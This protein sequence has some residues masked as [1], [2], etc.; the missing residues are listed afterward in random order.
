MSAAIY[1]RATSSETFCSITSLC[2]AV[3]LSRSTYYRHRVAQGT[4]AP[5]MALREAI[6]QVA[7]EMPSYGY[8]RITQ[9]LHR[10]GMPVNH[11][12]VLRLMREDNLLCLRKKPFTVT[13]DSAHDLPVYPN[14]A[15]KRVVTGLNQLWVSDITYIRLA[16]EFIYR[17]VILDACSRPV[18]S[19]HISRRLDAALTIAALEKA[20]E[21]RHPEP[22]LVHPSDRGVQYAATKYTDLLRARGIQISMS[23]RGN[24]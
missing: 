9:E 13:T 10:Q 4:S 21:E 22:G 16:S 14:L 7:L 2:R 23:R 12:R 6:Q 8:R 24:P 17:A 15:A 18:I 20:L 5:D 1:E 3:G 11:K 19:W